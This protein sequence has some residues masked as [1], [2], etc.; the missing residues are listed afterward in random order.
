MT[1]DEPV[2]CGIL[3]FEIFF[4]IVVGYWSGRRIN[5]RTYADTLKWVFVPH[6]AN[7]WFK[8]V[9]GLILVVTFSII[10]IGEAFGIA[11]PGP[12]FYSF[13]QPFIVLIIG[14]LWGEE[15]I[16]QKFGLRKEP[17]E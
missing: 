7:D 10:K 4:F 13:L 15:Y 8:K 5:F 9:V 6:S 14:I 16:R 17:G 11:E 2:V 1:I 12:F 3:L